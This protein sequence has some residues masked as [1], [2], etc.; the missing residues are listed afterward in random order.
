MYKI[1]LYDN[2][3]CPIADGVTCFFTDNLDEFE[4]NWRPHAHEEQWKRYERSKAGEIVT[5]YYS[6]SPDLNIVQE[7]KEA[8][9]LFEKELVIKD[10]LFTLL[11]AYRWESEIFAEETRIVFRGIKFKEECYLIGSYKM[12]GVCE[13]D[14]FSKEEKY[15]HIAVYGNPVINCNVQEKPLWYK[16]ED[17]REAYVY[18]REDFKEDSLE[19]YCFVTVGEYSEEELL[20][21]SIDLESD[22][23]FVYLM[24]DIPGEAG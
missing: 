8:E 23:T 5:D 16:A 7:D 11:N 9:I 24:R 12:K 2:N 6:D 3:C 14:F 20:N 17:G 1:T 22:E 18:Q 13:K 15:N 4:K 19:T 10:K 21:G